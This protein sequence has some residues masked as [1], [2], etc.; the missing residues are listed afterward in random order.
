VDGRAFSRSFKVKAQG[1]RFRSELL[2]AV[3]AGTR[4]G[5]APG[6]PLPWVRSDVTWWTRSGW[7]KFAEGTGRDDFRSEAAETQ[8]ARMSSN[9]TSASS[10]WKW[11]KLLPSLPFRSESR[12]ARATID[13]PRYTVW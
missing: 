10:P 8:V 12:A 5:P 2:V 3:G 9:K 13:K 6:Q 4:F 7:L 1:D 11:T